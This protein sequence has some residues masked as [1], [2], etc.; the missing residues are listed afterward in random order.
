MT[1][2]V[3]VLQDEVGF[4]IA[5]GPAVLDP[6]LPT[7][8]Q[9]LAATSPA[10]DPGDPS[11]WGAPDVLRSDVVSAMANYAQ[12]L[13]PR[14]RDGVAKVAVFETVSLLVDQLRQL[15][16][17]TGDKDLRPN[18]RIAAAKAA[19]EVARSVAEL[20]GQLESLAKQSALQALGASNK[21]PPSGA[22]MINNQV[23]L[24]KPTQSP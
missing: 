5:V 16:E 18:E 9:N 23:V 17:M 8:Q 1:M 20:A 13:E 2:S 3:D 6:L 24:D 14:L 4:D 19:S 10:D 12:W 15:K 11:V 7:Q 21:P 22:I